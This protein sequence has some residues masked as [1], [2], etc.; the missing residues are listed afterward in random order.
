[1]ELVLRHEKNELCIDHQDGSVGFTVLTDDGR[2]LDFSVELDQWEQ[3]KTFVNDSIYE[4][5]QLQELTKEE[6]KDLL[7]ILSRTSLSSIVK[8]I[9]EID[10]RLDV[11]NTLQVLISEHEKKT[12]EVKHIQKILD[13]NFWLFGE[14]YRLF[15][16]TE[17]ALRN[18][19][20]KYAKEILEIQDPELSTKPNNEV[21]LFLTKSENIG[22]KLHR[23]IIVEIKRASKK[24]TENNEYKQINDYRK[25]ILDQSLCKGENQY[26][27]FYLIGKD[28]DKGISELIESAQTHGEM[29]RGLTIKTNSGRVKVYVRK[30]A[31]ILEV[32][33]G[34]KMK[35]LKEK[36]EIQSK[37]LKS[38]PDEIVKDV[39]YE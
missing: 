12:L 5:E 6:Q 23:N 10:H 11:L 33:W 7:D 38:T 1:M 9:N 3:L 30:W 29:H 4:Y 18:V 34:A 31:D 2:Q 36:L 28:Y 21:D 25:K 24:L 35:Y 20:I 17:G 22:E 15:S 13:K 27:E 16:S 14:Q 19:L 8:T 37:H 32:E 26:W 39:L